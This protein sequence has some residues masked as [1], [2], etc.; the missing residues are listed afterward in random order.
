MKKNWLQHTPELLIRIII[1]YL[2]IQSGYGK[3]QD[4]NAVISYFT[5]LQIPWPALNAY[6]VAVIE[7][8]G[9][10]FLAMGLFT[11]FWSLLLAVIMFVALMTTQADALVS[12]SLLIETSEFLYLVFLLVLLVKGSALLSVDP[13]LRRKYL[14]KTCLSKMI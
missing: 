9:G 10:L 4:M 8:M 12:A 3:F 13:W 1:S 7:L 11:R 2:F 6:L 14:N 5:N